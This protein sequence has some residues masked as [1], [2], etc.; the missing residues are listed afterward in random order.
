[1]CR[2]T[3]KHHSS[4]MRFELHGF[5]GVFCM[6]VEAVFLYMINT[7]SLERM[8]CNILLFIVAVS[9]SCMAFSALPLVPH[10]P[11]ESIIF[12]KEWNVSAPHQ[13]A[14]RRTIA[15]MQFISV[16]L[17]I[18]MVAASAPTNAFIASLFKSESWFHFGV[19]TCLLTFI[20]SF[21]VPTEKFDNW[22]TY[23]FGIPMFIGTVAD[24]L[25]LGEWALVS[26]LLYCD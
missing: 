18:N 26:L 11:M 21:L 23:F 14:F 2:S 6:T 7:V 22:N 16:R 17:V 8:W 12:K 4:G 9:A 1:M 15:V 25:F 19:Q 24:T 3:K 5:L 13:A 10:A 20:Y